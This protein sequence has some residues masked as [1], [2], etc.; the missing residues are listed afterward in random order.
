MKTI[1][2]TFFLFLFQCLFGCKTVGK[3][4]NE[5]MNISSDN[6]EY[7]VLEKEISVKIIRHLPSQAICGNLA[8]ASVTI[9]KT[10]E[11]DTIRILDLC[12]TLDYN[13]NETIKVL[14]QEKPQFNVMFPYIKIQNPT[15]KELEIVKTD[16]RVLKTTYGLLPR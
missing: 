5:V 7:F 3:S 14:P 2:F 15:T 4:K 11:G 12:N 13:E 10:Q 1:K 16:K 9:V 6:W 8:F